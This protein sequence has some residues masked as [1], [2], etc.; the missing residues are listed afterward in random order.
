MNQTIRVIEDSSLRALARTKVKAAALQINT[1]LERIIDMDAV[2][3]L[4]PLS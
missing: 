4:Q 1:A 2:K 3:W